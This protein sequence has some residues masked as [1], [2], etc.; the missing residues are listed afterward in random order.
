MNVQVTSSV[1]IASL[2]TAVTLT[3]QSKWPSTLPDT[4]TGTWPIQSL[5]LYYQWIY[6]DVPII[7]STTNQ[8]TIGSASASN[9]GWY[10]CVVTSPEV[11]MEFG[12][13]NNASGKV[14][15]VVG[16]PVVKCALKMV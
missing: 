13:P 8:Y 3:C 7:N 14:F 2:N 4:P 12:L 1:Q 15:V 16:K 9:A 6:N 5:T 11:Q 10:T